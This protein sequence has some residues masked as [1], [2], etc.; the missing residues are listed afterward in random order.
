MG[1]VPGLL[2]WEIVKN[3]SFLVKELGNITQCAQFSSEVTISTIST[4]T[5]SLVWQT[6]KLLPFI[7]PKAALARLGAVHRSLKVSKSGVKE[8]N[9]QALKVHGRK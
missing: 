9:R 6:R 1:T 2:V 7:L 5:S 3:N 4:L 8:K